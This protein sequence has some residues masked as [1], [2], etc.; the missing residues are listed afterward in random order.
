MSRVALWRRTDAIAEPR[1]NRAKALLLTLIAVTSLLALAFVRPEEAPLV[2]NVYK[3]RAK[4]GAFLGS[5][6]LIWQF[7]LGFRGAVSPVLP[8]LAW[9]GIVHQRL[10]QFGVPIIVLHPVFIGLYC[11][12]TRGQNIFALEMSDPFSQRVLLG[13][14]ALAVVGFII[15]TSLV[16]SKMGFYRWLCTHLSAYLVPPLAFVHSFLLG[17]TIRGTWLQAYWW[18]LGA[19]GLSTRRGADAVPVGGP[20]LW[21]DRRRP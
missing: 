7:L 16:R 17:P 14:L 20:E 5:M 2:V 18:L 21:R 9:V 6:F 13:M 19:R 11:L 8:D 12:E 15:V 1:L 4:T 10:G 3:Y